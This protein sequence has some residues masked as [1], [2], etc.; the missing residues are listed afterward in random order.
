MAIFLYF[1]TW[2]NLIKLDQ[3]WSNLIKLDYSPFTMRIRMAIFFYF[4]GSNLSKLDQT[5]SNWIFHQSRNASIKSS[6]QIYH[7][8]R[9]G[10][11]FY[12]FGCLQNP[13]QHLG[14]A[15]KAGLF[16][17]IFLHNIFLY[18]TTNCSIIDL[19][20]IFCQLILCCYLIEEIHC[21]WNY[22]FLLIIKPR[23]KDNLQSQ[24]VIF[25]DPVFTNFF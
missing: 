18:I 19:M 16:L 6:S 13:H 1:S 3:T 15:R 14:S 10:L 7:E 20:D 9:N 25:S 21:I 17:V 22:S 23:K 8:D 4:F 12:F 11:F 2:S 5:W 24:W